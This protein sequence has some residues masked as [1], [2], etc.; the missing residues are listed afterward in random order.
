M[1]DESL[2][3]GENATV[4]IL[5]WFSRNPSN[6]VYVNELSRIVN[7]SNASCSRLLNLLEN[8]GLLI[9]EKMGNA[10]YYALKDN[11]VTREMKRFFLM[12]RIYESGLVDY[13]KENDP[14]LTNLI[15]YGSC[16]T[17]KYDKRSDMD[18]LAISNSKKHI[19]LETFQE[20]LD[21]RIELTTM[22]IG[23]WIS[24]KNNI[25]GFY[26]EVKK[27]GIILFGGELP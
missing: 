19:D 24:M 10:H 16:A 25:D 3:L 14:S 11:Y 23:R 20:F 21:I 1:K 6:K 15:L 9:R 5:E 4:K 7:L 27:D 12:I 8:K 13:L 17:G 22:N 26:K 18:I 2:L